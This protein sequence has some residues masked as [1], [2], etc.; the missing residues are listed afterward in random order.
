MNDEFWQS[1]RYLLIAAG[2]YLATTGKLPI[3]DVPAMADAIIQVAGGVIAIGSMAWGLY[4]RAGTK[5][6]P[7]EVAQ[8]PDVATVNVATGAV[9]S[10]TK[11]RAR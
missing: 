2:T 4:V 7:I 10:P 9:E 11:V 8:R 5:S 6:V 3:A 1:V